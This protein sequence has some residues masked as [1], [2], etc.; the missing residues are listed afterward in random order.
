MDLP[1]IP[2][3]LNFK[4]GPLA[5]KSIQLQVGPN[6]IGRAPSNQIV[7]N[8][9]GTSDTHAQVAVEP[10]GVWVA[11][12]ASSTGTFVNGNR[13]TAS[14]WLQ[15]NDQ[16]QIGSS[17][18]IFR[19]SGIPQVTSPQNQRSGCLRNCIIFAIILFL[20][21]CCFSVLLGAYG[22][23]QYQSGNLSPQ[24]ILNIVGFGVGEIRIAN[25]TDGS[26]KADLYELDA[27]T[28]NPVFYE[29]LRL[30][31]LDIGAIGS[32]IPG[33]Y[34][35]RVTNPDS[36]TTWGSCWMEIKGG[37]AYQLVAVPEGIAITLEGYEPLDPEELDFLTSS[38][39]QP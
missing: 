3:H 25:L 19:I 26:L 24:T 1:S 22:Y 9:Q 20:I 21:L 16:I 32:I 10:N 6:L 38:L 14:V 11:D 18:F 4:S 29:A 23:T 7:L 36:G 33:S 27:E 34:E 37:A 5:G 15:N 2:A 13:L 17:T 35:L 8:D 12:L 28:G 39:C 31:S 30:D